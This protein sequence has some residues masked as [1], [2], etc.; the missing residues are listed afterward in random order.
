M[1]KWIA[2]FIALL[3]ISPLAARMPHGSALSSFWNGNLAQLSLSASW[4]SSG[5]YLPLDAMKDARDWVT[6]TGALPV[7]I[8][9]EN[10]NGYP[11]NNTD[12]ASVGGW[13]TY[14]DIPTSAERA[15]PY[16]LSWT[17]SG[18]TTIGV[19]QN[20]QASISSAPGCSISGLQVSGT[21][22]TVTV[23]YTTQSP[24]IQVLS[25]SSGGPTSIKL[26]N[27]ADA[28]SIA[29]G[30]V[31]KTSKW[32]SVLGQYYGVIRD[33]NRSTANNSDVAYWA[34]RTPVNWFSYS[35]N[36]YFPSSLVTSGSMTLVSGAS[37]TLAF[38]G[39]ALTDKAHVIFKPSAI[40]APSY[41]SAQTVSTGNTLQLI[42]TTGIIAG[43]VAGD[44]NN[45]SALHSNVKVVSV[46]S[47]TNTVTF[48]SSPFW[49]GVS[50]GDTIYFSPMLNVNG[51]GAVP[52]TSV[53]A[54][55]FGNA[56][57][58]NQLYAN[59][60]TLTYDSQLGVFLTWNSSTQNFGLTGGSPPE[61]FTQCANEIGAHPW[62]VLPP[63]AMDGPTDYA[64]QLAT[65]AKTNLLPGLI[66]RFEGPNE[67]WN[68]QFIATQYA[69][70]K[71]FPRSGINFDSANWY[72]RAIS[73]VGQAVSSVYGADRT[74]YKVEACLAGNGSVNAEKITAGTY[75]SGT[76]AVS[77]TTST[78][79]PFLQIGN[80]VTVRGVTGTGSVASLN[81]AVTATSGSGSTTLNYTIATGL[82]MTIT[83]GSTAY[84]EATGDDGEKVTSPEYVSSGG[85]AA[86]NWI[87]DICP[88]G[89]YQ[90]ST[91]GTTNEIGYAYW[92]ANG[93]SGA[94][95]TSLV[96]TF[97]QGA[98]D[99]LPT[100]TL[101]WLQHSWWPEY[102]NYLATYTGTATIG[103]TM[104]E[105]GYGTNAGCGYSNNNCAINATGINL[106]SS[107][108]AT[109]A[110][111]SV[112]QGTTTVLTV[113]ATASSVTQSGNTIT[114][115]GTI[116]GAFAT[117]SQ[118]YGTGFA[119]QTALY[120]QI[121]GTTGGAGTY[122][123][124][125]TQT[126]STPAAVTTNPA[127]NY[128]CNTAGLCTGGHPTTTL[129]FGG[130]CGLNGLDPAVL[131]ATPTTITVNVN[132]TGFTGCTTG[133]AA[134]DGAGGNP[135]YVLT[136]ENGVKT[137]TDPTNL[138]ATELSFFQSFY[139]TG[140]RF[141]S[142]YGSAGQT[143]WDQF[144]PDVYVATPPV[145]TAAQAFQAA[146]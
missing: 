96:H 4:N 52:I 1:R 124:F 2:L 29:S 129:T 15:G 102:T 35:A 8:T 144:N 101:Y 110:V 60:T 117:G 14:A 36:G 55:V 143:D 64:T 19:E 146:P 30:Y 138:Y 31:C 22:C 93:A 128:I 70:V 121:S 130:G 79:I 50:S 23:S 106:N 33:L 131:S 88:T 139:S 100:L 42:S 119:G 77:L 99:P 123:A 61:W 48:A 145:V 112:S 63:Y 73:Q 95:Q 59:W 94:Q 132:S 41:T 104:Y 27:S 127:W 82:T 12:L 71:E 5:E 40:T 21:A 11:S 126:V 75:N 24:G 136:F 47:G 69:Y 97:L 16:I 37:Y 134:Y 26:Y 45:S 109:Q 135:G 43:M 10:A 28:A 39:F 32:Q 13:V 9:S 76:G 46:N 20:G 111:T 87:T 115:G 81:G 107:T 7:N 66:P 105:G 62:Y 58:A 54:G 53:A 92:Y 108:S 118:I 56:N 86:Y 142:H 103:F 114:I 125:P 18:S 98:L 141:P 80:V 122:T 65:Y 25:V 17:G 44:A 83:P 137:N 90:S 89:Y 113:G 67:T 78:N 34:D 49:N 74:K 140:G 57:S 3:A 51:T 133:T 120:G 91:V 6:I 68:N 116:T 85:S 38:S 84:T 72:G